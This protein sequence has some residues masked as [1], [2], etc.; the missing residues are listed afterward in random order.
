MTKKKI[1]IIPLLKATTAIALNRYGLNFELSVDT[2]FLKSVGVLFIAVVYTH[3]HI[4][5]ITLSFWS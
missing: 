3:S 4:A 5:F 1:P 2:A